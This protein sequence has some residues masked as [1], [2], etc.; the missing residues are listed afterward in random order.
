MR[1]GISVGRLAETQIAD[2]AG[3]RRLPHPDSAL[4]QRPLQVFLAGHR[5][6]LQKFQNGPL[7]QSFIHYAYLTMVVNKYSF[8]IKDFAEP[9]K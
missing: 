9:V 8:N 5:T 4:A 6:L 3:K 2:I 7:P 1:Q